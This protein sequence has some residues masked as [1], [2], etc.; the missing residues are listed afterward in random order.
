M[1]AAVTLEQVGGGYPITAVHLV[2]EAEITGADE[3]AFQ[4]LAAQAKTNRPVSRS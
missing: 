1:A 4:T 3:V 2:L